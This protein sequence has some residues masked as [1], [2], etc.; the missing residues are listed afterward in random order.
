MPLCVCGSL[1]SSRFTESM[2]TINVEMFLYLINV[3][4]LAT[5][6][7]W[8]IDPTLFSKTCEVFT[9]LFLC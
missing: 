2:Q 8:F 4:A 1:L 6:Y 3:E 9:G 7:Y 5:S